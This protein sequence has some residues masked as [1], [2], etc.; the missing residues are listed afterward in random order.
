MWRKGSA[1]RH[2]DAP[3]EV[4][5]AAITDL[6]R[7]PSWNRRMTAVVELP[8]R[9]AAGSEWEVSFS[10]MG[11]R[12]NSRSTVLEIDPGRRRFVHR[13]KRVDDDPTDTVWTWQVDADGAGSRV[14]VSWELRPRTLVRKL[15]AAPMRGFQ[16]PRTDAPSSLAALAE[17]CEQRRPDATNAAV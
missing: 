12:F 2:V 4:V 1:E 16:I 15:L 17:R 13:S 6:A 10:I 8:E 9:L 3:P 7:L 14:T 5:F 11:S